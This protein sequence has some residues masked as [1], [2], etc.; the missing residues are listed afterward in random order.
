M[1]INSS[2]PAGIDATDAETRLVCGV[3]RCCGRRRRANA[4]WY[5]EDCDSVQARESDIRTDRFSQLLE[6][7][8]TSA[9][10]PL[11]EFRVISETRRRRCPKPNGRRSRWRSCPSRG[12]TG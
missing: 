1:P 11:L 5:S 3:P 9:R 6:L 12:A 10:T 8:E 7:M 2:K 4:F